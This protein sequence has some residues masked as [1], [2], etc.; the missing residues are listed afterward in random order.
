MT[1]P[2]AGQTPSDGDDPDDCLGASAGRR[3]ATRPFIDLIVAQLWFAFAYAT[4]LLLPKLLAADYHAG[5][6]QV[7]FVMAAFGVMSLAASPGIGPLVRRLGSRGTMVA[8]NLVLAGSALGFLAM[9]GPGLFPAVLRG[10]QGVAWALAFGGGM[11]LCAAIAPPDRLGQALG[12]FGAAS[13]AMS[14]V[15]PVLAEPIAARWGAR[16][17]FA[18]AALAAAIGAHRCARLPDDDDHPVN[19][20]GRPLRRDGRF[21][22]VWARMPIY[23]TLG[24]ISLAGGALFTF[25]APFALDRGVGD[26]RAFFVAYTVA[27]LASRFGIARVIDGG[28]H[29]RA[30]AGAGLIYAVAVGAMA[31]LGPWHLV[32]VGAVFGVAHG[33][34][35]PALMALVLTDVV[36]IDRPRL[37]GWANGAMNLGIVALAP[38]GT[39]IQRAGYPRTF[40]TVG[41]STGLVSLALLAPTGRRLRRAF[42]WR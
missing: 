15:A 9:T 6:R 22:A 13:L 25:V 35:Y 23:V 16:P 31:V 36:A 37:L 39:V 42:G 33:I 5:A 11:T 29:G 30:A 21:S 28:G 19:D 14:A 17:T 26:V 38:L 32:L 1:V 27:A 10:L 8:A 40:A 41:I 12:I 18:L 4:F 3:L 7:G 24:T 20:N 34:I 2:R